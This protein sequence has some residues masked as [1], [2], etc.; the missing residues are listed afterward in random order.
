[1]IWTAAHGQKAEMKEMYFPQFNLASIYLYLSILSIYLSIYIYLFSQLVTLCKGL[2]DH[3]SQRCITWIPKLFMKV[4]CYTHTILVSAKTNYLMSVRIPVIP[5]N[6]LSHSLSASNLCF[7][8]HTFTPSVLVTCLVHYSLRPM[9]FNWCW[10][11]I[12]KGL[13]AHVSVCVCVREIWFS[14]VWGKSR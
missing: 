3:H 14:K 12:S 5:E 2:F 8:F 13:C 11:F 9:R 10:C 4:N 6:T 7:W 1:M